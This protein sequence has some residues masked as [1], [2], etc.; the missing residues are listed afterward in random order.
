MDVERIQKLNSLALDLI[1]QGL[2]KDREEA[3]K[4]AQETLRDQDSSD[5]SQIQG[6]NPAPITG[7]SNQTKNPELSQDKIV[8][9]LEKNTQFLVKTI[10]EFQT[11]ITSL[12]Q[13]V[14]QLKNKVNYSK[15]PSASQ[16]RE[17]TPLPTE[18]Q[19]P[20]DNKPATP[21]AQQ[22]PEQQ[23]QQQ[24]QPAAAAQSSSGHPRSGNYND[25]DVSI[26]KFFYMGSK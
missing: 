12:E 26:E 5:F 22:A 15:L 13:E 23:Q 6:Q 16:V 14:A 10:K 3:I 9:I 7:Q 18:T 20:V 25:Q 17:P 2:A 24:Q 1:R 8:Q 11:K 19:A 21:Q 4:M